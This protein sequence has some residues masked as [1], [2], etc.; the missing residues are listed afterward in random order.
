MVSVFD[1]NPPSPAKKSRKAP[2]AS[3]AKQQDAQNK[4]PYSYI[5][6]IAMAIKNAE[7]KRY[8]LL[9][10]YFCSPFFILTKCPF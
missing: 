4:P 6:L 10:T 3:P 8:V 1:S 9:N 7:E 5:A 2:A